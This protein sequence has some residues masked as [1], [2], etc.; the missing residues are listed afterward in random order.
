[1]K[2]ISLVQS[3]ITNQTRKQWFNFLGKTVKKYTKQF[4]KFF[5]SYW[6][7]VTVASQ[8]NDV[9]LLK[10]WSEEGN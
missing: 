7:L 5:L 9:L 2:D 6:V 8:V 3:Y 4:P 10:G 1:M